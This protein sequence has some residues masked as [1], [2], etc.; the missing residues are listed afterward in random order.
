LSVVLVGNAAAFASQLRGVGF[1]SYETVESAEL[2]LTAASLKRSGTRAGGREDPHASSLVPVSAFRRESAYTAA[3]VGGHPQDEPDPARGRRAR[4][5]DQDAAGALVDRAIEAKG[6]LETLRGVKTIVVKQTVTTASGDR[7]LEV[8]TTNYIQYPDRFRTE[9]R[10]PDGINVQVFDGA[11][12]WAK[13]ARGVRETPEAVARD[14]RTTLRRDPIALLLGIK[15]GALT[16]RTL[17][18]VKD[19]AGARY[20]ALEVSAPD[21]N[22]I[23]LLIDPESGQIARQTFVAGAPGR[24]IIEED[25]SDYRPVGGVQIAFQASRRNGSQKIERRVTEIRIN[26]PVDP[27]LFRRPAS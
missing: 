6:G 8:E 17:P 19:A 21:L 15:S 20:R 24:P 23:V 25:L 9:T 5:P 27:A 18:D 1:A 10:V 11:R 26:A 13:D 12:L 14:A 2:D 16:A 7:P 22:P 4:D 3:Q